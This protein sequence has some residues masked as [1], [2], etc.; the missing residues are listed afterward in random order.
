[1]TR[2]RIATAPKGPGIA[3]CPHCHRQVNELSL[4]PTGIGQLCFSCL[5]GQDAIGP[6]HSPKGGSK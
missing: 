5:H 2:R 6:N 1:M 3:K 4:Y